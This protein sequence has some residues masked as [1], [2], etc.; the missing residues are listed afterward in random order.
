MHK[1]LFPT[2]TQH[3]DLK[4]ISFN[5]DWLLQE[6]SALQNCERGFF[7][8]GGG[9]GK[10]KI[11]LVSKKENILLYLQLLYETICTFENCFFN[12]NT[13]TLSKYA[14]NMVC[15]AHLASVDEFC[16]VDQI[17]CFIM[18]NCW[19]KM[20]IDQWIPPLNSGSNFTEAGLIPGRA[21]E[22]IT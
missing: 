11:S 16:S 3:C 22:K 5:K 18:L 7:F 12:T 8:S 9:E 17:C 4:A 19:W 13:L 1:Y 6:F 15:P 14:W 10:W 20:C 21:F 2:Q